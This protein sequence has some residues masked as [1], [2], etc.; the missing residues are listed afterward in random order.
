MAL[1]ETDIQRQKE[2]QQAEELL[3]S[4]RQE[5]GLA[6]GLFLGDFVADW[7]M[8]YPRLSH[9]EQVDV[10]RAIAELRV[11]STNTSI[12]RRSIARRTSRD[13]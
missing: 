5:L 11:S 12:R 8:P 4:G 3:F 7:A 2:I 13:T 6:K 9:A 10:D 1:S